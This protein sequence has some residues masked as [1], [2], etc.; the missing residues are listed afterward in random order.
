M[1]SPPEPGTLHLWRFPIPPSGGRAA[2]FEPILSADERDRAAR[3][4][5]EGAKRRFVTCRGVLRLLLAAYLDSAPGSLD[6]GY[7]LHGKPYLKKP[8]SALRFNVSHSGD[9]GVAAFAGGAEIGVDIEQVRPRTDLEGLAARYFA[10]QERD[11][12]LSV[13]KPG[14]LDAFFR[15]WTCKEAFIKAR[16]EGL[17]YPL[18]QFEVRFDEE[19][20]ARLQSIGG[21]PQEAA[22]WTLMEF[23]AAQGYRGAYVCQGPARQ[24]LLRELDPLD[25]GT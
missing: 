18:D 13:P 1:E 22:H 17:S 2:D 23:E 20:P 12:L 15:L 8:A 9:L 4:R 6:F 11:W 3:L 25:A 16:G 24:P 14:R 19:R 10:P 5:N 21:N 7:T